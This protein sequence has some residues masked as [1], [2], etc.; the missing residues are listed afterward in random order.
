MGQELSGASI[1]YP[2]TQVQLKMLSD[3][4]T[5]SFLFSFSELKILK[6]TRRSRNTSNWDIW[7][8]DP[9]EQKEKK[10]EKTVFK[11][12]RRKKRKRQRF[13]FTI[14]VKNGLAEHQLSERRTAEHQ[15]AEHRLSVRNKAVIEFLE[16]TGEFSKLEFCLID[17]APA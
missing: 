16:T 5:S 6:N 17:A 13:F 14:W 2:D 15:T 10:K 12:F 8:K 11:K 7:T 3:R 9:N 4:L 1:C